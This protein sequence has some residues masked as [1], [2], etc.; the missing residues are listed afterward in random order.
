M[1]QFT[2][3]I[4]ASYASSSLSYRVNTLR[5]SFIFRKLRSTTLRPL[6]NFLLYHHGFLRFR[7]GGTTGRIPHFFAFARHL[8]PSYA[9]SIN[10]ALPFLIFGGTRSINFR[11]SGPSAAE[12]DD[13]LRTIGKF[14]SATMEWILV[15]QPPRLLPMDCGPFFCAHQ[16]H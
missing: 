4:K 9:L 5:N 3:A 6:Y 1:T 2:K 15:V 8:F 16:Y 12:P 13:K 7:F 14:S 11:P 10:N